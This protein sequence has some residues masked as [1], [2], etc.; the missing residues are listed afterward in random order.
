MIAPSAS[1]LISKLRHARALLIPF[2]L[3]TA[4][5]PFAHAGDS[6][7][8]SIPCSLSDTEAAGLSG[9]A[10]TDIHAVLNYKK[11]IASLLE[12]GK[13]DQIDCVADSVRTGKETFS[14]GMWKLHA[15][16]SALEKPPQ[17]PTA[18]DWVRH[19]QLMQRWVKTRPDSITARIGLAESYT[20][21]G[22]DSRGTGESDTVS[23]S[24]WKLL[25]AGASKGRQ[26]LEQ[27]S[28]LSAKDPEWYFAMQ[29]IALA[30]GWKAAERKA[31]LD[32]AV[33]FEPAY[34]YYYRAYAY[35]LLPK[36]YG[37]KGEA[38]D[39]LRQTADNIGGDAGD[40]LYFRVAGLL[41][42]SSDDRNLELSWPRILKGF[43][44]VETQSGTAPEN[45]NR[46]ARIAVTFDHA[47]MADKMFKKIGDQWSEDIWK[48][49]SYYESVKQW[50]ARAAKARTVRPDEQ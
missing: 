34:Y 16:Y 37:K 26:I 32:Q 42:S 47:I 17:H 19:M 12:A 27:S 39:F 5:C 24:G 18:V 31:L 40:A 15:V 10:S 1:A 20:A 45:W 38:E 2:L 49:S 36:W 48:T 30:Q 35:S 23:E 41:V 46:L 33:R 13:F 6:K 7:P 3:V 11:T 28:D 4:S 43:A 50:A 22:W 44:A 29:D 9:D 14:G 21:F 25:E 8:R